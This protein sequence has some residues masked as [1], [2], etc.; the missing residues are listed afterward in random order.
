MSQ[1]L[2]VRAARTRSG[3]SRLLDAGLN[4]DDRERRRVSQQLHEGPLQ[5][6]LAA[7]QEV[8]DG[9]QPALIHAVRSA[10]EALEGTTLAANALDPAP[11]SAVGLQERLRAA[12]ER[13]GGGRLRV[14]AGTPVPEADQ[15]LLLD[16]ALRLG[17]VLEHHG[18]GDAELTARVEVEGEET[19]LW[20][21]VP[22]D[23]GALR[24]ASGDVVDHATRLGCSVLLGSGG[25]GRTTFHVRL[26]EPAQRATLAADALGRR[27]ARDAA[28]VRGVVFATAAAWTLLLGGRVTVLELVVL[29]AALLIGGA[30][31]AVAYR[32][33]WRYPLSSA[34]VPGIA[35][36]AAAVAVSG[37]GDSPLTV[38]LPLFPFALVWVLDRQESMRLCV[39]TVV[40]YLVGALADLAVSGSLP[41]LD[42]TGRF[43]LAMA[44][45]TAMVAAVG[46]TRDRLAA[47]ADAAEVERRAVLS[48]WLA[49]AGA[50]R[51]RLAG[52]LRDDVVA[53]LASG[54][55]ELDAALAVAEEQR[56]GPRRVAAQ[57][58]ARATS[59]L[60]AVADELHPP[61]LEHGGLRAAVL[62]DV[63]DLTAEAGLRAT[64][65]VDD[66]VDRRHDELVIALLRELVRNT[67]R[68]A[69]ASHLTIDVH[70]SAVALEV[71][72]V[73]DGR[74]MAP[75]RP[76]AAFAEGRRGL[77][78][79]RERAEAAGGWLRVV[80]SPGRG[81]TVTVRLPR[82]WT[83]AAP[84]E[85]VAQVG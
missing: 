74:G 76:A 47:Q 37:G 81:T 70:H 71:E 4:L 18:R 22:G 31:I 5:A 41:P 52:A 36:V 85:P 64:I 35:L 68:H 32:Q 19:S 9:D 61:A 42:V 62:T 60:R 78:V 51:T 17:D 15:E 28:V 75:D 8:E 11:G 7:R 59:A 80:S 65:R 6:V 77:A 1:P 79:S 40:A 12:L 49:G 73:D 55:R 45:T 58:L 63:G 3:T 46:A 29:V 39:A 13:Q 16:L 56:A 23:L 2:V 24:R 54:R 10:V 43:L 82:T 84:V 33:W 14:Q 48:D 20:V 72:V 44:W 67:C 25:S 21:D 53:W 57:A 83:P 27:R 26:G 34:S 38:L 50:D 30:G 69:E 66:A